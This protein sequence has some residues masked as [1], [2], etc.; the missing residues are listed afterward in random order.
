MITKVKYFFIAIISFF[1]IVVLGELSV[2]RASQLLSNHAITSYDF[3]DETL[4]KGSEEFDETLSVFEQVAK[5]YDISIMITEANV[6][7]GN[8]ESDNCY[9]INGAEDIIRSELEKTEYNSLIS[10]KVVFV[11]KDISQLKKINNFTDLIFIGDDN[12]VEN[13]RIYLSK[14]LAEDYYMPRRDDNVYMYAYVMVAIACV[15]IMCFCISDAL[16][17]RHHNIIRYVYGESRSAIYLNYIVKDSIIISAIFAAE[18]LIGVHLN[19]VLLAMRYLILYLIIVLSINALMYLLDLLVNISTVIKDKNSTKTLLT[20]S[21]SIKWLITL[22]AVISI[23]FGINEIKE[24]IGFIKA[25]SFFE[26]IKGHNFSNI[27][28]KKGSSMMDYL[29]DT[30]FEE[31]ITEYYDELDP[32]LICT[33]HYS[34]RDGEEEPDENIPDY[35]Y[36]NVRAKDYLEKAI[37]KELDNYNKQFLVIIPDNSDAQSKEKLVEVLDNLFLTSEHELTE[38]DYTFV[39]VDTDYEIIAV[40]DDYGNFSAVDNIPV[41]FCTQPENEWK[42]PYVEMNMANK[43]SYYMIKTDDELKDK[44]TEEYDL[45]AFGRTNCYDCFMKI[46]KFRKT[47]LLY[48]VGIAIISIITQVLIFVFVIGLEFKLQR[49]ELILKKITGYRLWQRY[50]SVIVTDLILDAVCF[51][52]GFYVIHRAELSIYP[53]LIVFA[54]IL[55]Q[56]AVLFV[57]N[58][59]RLESTN[60]LRVLKEGV[61]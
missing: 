20:I 2:V 48:T 35:I 28:V 58:I 61:L 47:T 25:Q 52:I 57:V 39:Y 16:F 36:A 54:A 49:K 23:C 33:E 45:E 10:G 37:N 24:N 43:R 12:K 42:I 6:E 15:L 26:D 14:I 59:I 19:E 60:I 41:V 3:G 8:I 21:Y 1:V 4:Y 29:E 44:I 32:L 50:M 31:I 18:L 46:W 17:K 7:D 27:R 56:E 38:D 13:A 53:A 30:S 55:V 22:F 40:E 51:A 11:F 34:V 9:S 5:K